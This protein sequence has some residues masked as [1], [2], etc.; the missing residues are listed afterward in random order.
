MFTRTGFFVQKNSQF[1]KREYNYSG[2]E[3]L[4]TIRLFRSRNNKMIS[5]VCGGLETLVKVDATII[6]LVFALTTFFTGIMPGVLL[7]LLFAIIIPLETEK[8]DPIIFIENEEK[9]VD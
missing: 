6:R 7:Y 8:K 9:T 2:G 4:D 5:G 1:P 3:S